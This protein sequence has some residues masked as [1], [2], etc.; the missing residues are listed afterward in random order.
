MLPFSSKITD[1][2]ELFF[3]KKNETP[4]A[5]R[6]AK[7]IAYIDILFITQIYTASIFVPASFI[8]VL[9]SKALK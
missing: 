3:M 1:S 4:P 2:E 7:T 8:K 6:K 5:I 9:S